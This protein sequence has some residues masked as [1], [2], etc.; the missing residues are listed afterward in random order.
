LKARGSRH[1]GQ[2]KRDPESSIFEQF[3]IPAF[4]GM[5]E[6]VSFARS[7]IYYLTKPPTLSVVGRGGEGP[8]PPVN[9]HCWRAIFEKS[10]FNP[11]QARRRTLSEVLPLLKATDKVGGSLRVPGMGKHLGVEVPYRS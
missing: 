11:Y 2:A 4:A 3:W 6:E 10:R 9:Q 1:S 7:S 5:T 8:T